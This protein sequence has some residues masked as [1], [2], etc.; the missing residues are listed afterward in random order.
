MPV[1]PAISFA[2]GL[3]P[4]TR[5]SL[6]NHVVTFDFRGSIPADAGEPQAVPDRLSWPRVYPRRSG[7]ASVLRMTV[8]VYGGL[9]PQ[10]RG[11][12]LH[13]HI[14]RLK[15]GAIPAGAGEP[16]SSSPTT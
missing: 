13:R 15:E 2:M 7:G 3:S 16:R 9:S 8:S 6:R 1:A 14:G 5:G 12:P 11:S 4:Q 10:A